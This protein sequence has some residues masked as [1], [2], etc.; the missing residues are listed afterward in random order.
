M[1]S[2]TSAATTT[3]P[4]TKTVAGCPLSTVARGEPWLLLATLMRKRELRCGPTTGRMAARTL[5]PPSVQ[6]TTS[7]DSMDNNPDRSP[8]AQAA[9][10]R[11]V[12]ARP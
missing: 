1:T 8:V 12:S 10:N 11:S 2:S 4:S 5:P 9:R 6:T 3:P 7:S